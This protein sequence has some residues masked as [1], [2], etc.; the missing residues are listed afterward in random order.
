[1]STMN[2][3]PY[4]IVRIVTGLNG[5]VK[6]AGSIRLMPMM[7]NE[8]K[9]A[10][11][12]RQTQIGLWTSFAD[13]YAIEIVAG[14]GFDWLLIDGE[15]APNDLRSVLAQIQAMAGHPTHP[16]VRIPI[17]DPVLIKQYLDIGAHTLLV[18]IVE[19]GEQARQLVSATRY[20]PDGIRGVATA[21]ASSWGAISDYFQHASELVCLLIQVE[22]RKGLENLDDI[23]AVDGVDGIFIGPSDLAA[24]LG[25]LGNPGHPDVVSAIE[26]AIA[27]IVKSS[28]AAGILTVDP[29]LAQS[30][31]ERG[32]TFC[33]VGVDTQMLAQAARK[34]ARRFKTNLAPGSGVKPSA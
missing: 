13:P 25:H 14:A 17:G 10:L 12:A 5:R 32:V 2:F 3:T 20:P 34:L 26:S 7:K 27:R 16:V 21:R 1:M 8:F 11:A 29:T 4:R 33:A 9:A 28:K 19:T 15:H 30:Y 24:S 23:M 6:T 31:I 18:P 22:T